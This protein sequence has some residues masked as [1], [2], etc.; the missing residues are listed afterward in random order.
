MV[1]EVKIV[2]NGPSKLQ[3]VR[4]VKDITGLGLKDSKD[5]VDQLGVIIS[6]V[7]KRQAQEI[8]DVMTMTGATI[9]IRNTKLK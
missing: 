8:S 6:D 4:A 1:W 9:E 2:K 7:T 5:I 3:E